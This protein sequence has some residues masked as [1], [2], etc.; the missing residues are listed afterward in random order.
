M[1]I[2][3]A[4]LLEFQSLI[5][6][7]DTA[8]ERECVKYLEYAVDILL[9]QTPAATVSISLEQRS[10]YGRSDYIA[11]A[12]LRSDTGQIERHMVFWELKAPQCHLVEIDD[13]ATR[14]RPTKDLVKAETQL[15]HYVHQASGDADLKER[16]NI[17]YASNIHAGGIIIGRDSHIFK[18]SKGAT[19][20]SANHS[21]KI[22]HAHI[23]NKAQFRVMTW[24]RILDFFQKK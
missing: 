12:D 7:Q 8:R 1:P 20:E 10:P 18:P 2:S 24:D 9:P 14:Y 5:D 19:L 3:D 17:R 4:N 16:F 15:L 22:R 23:Y 13:A 6:D 21:L 11:V